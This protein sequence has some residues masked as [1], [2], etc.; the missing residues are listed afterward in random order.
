M[1]EKETL[2]STRERAAILA[3]IARRKVEWNRLAG[4]IEEAG[5]AL[6]LLEQLEESG[7]P[8]L[9]AVESASVTLDELEERV[10]SYEH[11]GIHLITV[12]DAA[13]PMNLR[14][15]HDRPPA[16]FLRGSL[17]PAD[18]RSVAVVGSRKASDGGLEKAAEI[19]RDLVARD[20]VVVSG[21]AAGI[22]TAAHRA[23]LEAGGRTVA[24][25]GTGLRHHFPKQNAELQEQ[26]GRESAVVSQFW[27]GQEARRWTFPQR[28]AVMS[29]LARATAVVEA[30]NK[31][32]A[33]MQARLAIEH[34]RPVFLLRSLLRHEWA[35]TYANERPGTYVVE[36]SEEIVH[37]LDRLYADE[38]ALTA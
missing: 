29:G 24:V 23:A 11:E 19:A 6:S 28:N 16:L 25:I 20:Y 35:Q 1:F 4:S 7:D 32:G 37:I 5:S 30:G 13:Y 12:L 10:L 26:L 3:L 17:S 22:D 33:R 27:P 34:G 18:E 2:V 15:V 9:F 31:S 8:R 14:M 36:T 21:L 38:L